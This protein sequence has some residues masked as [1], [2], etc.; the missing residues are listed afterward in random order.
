MTRQGRQWGCIDKNNS[1]RKER[2]KERERLE[3]TS[4]AFITHLSMESK[5]RSSMT[6][7]GHCQ[8][9]S[10]RKHIEWHNKYDQP[11]IYK[12]NI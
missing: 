8:L 9:P 12:Q 11:K 3:E 5:M 10:M 4:T 2:E 7:V 6:A 1:Y